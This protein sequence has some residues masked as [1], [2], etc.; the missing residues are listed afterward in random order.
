MTEEQQI[1]ARLSGHAGL[2]ALVGTRISPM[3]SIQAGSLPCVTFQRASGGRR[4]NHDGADDMAESS[5]Q[6]DAWAASYDGVKAVAEQLRAALDASESP[7]IGWYVFIDNETDDYEEDTGIY[8]VM[9]LAT[10]WLR[11]TSV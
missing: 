8:R 7:L 3:R 6:F 10:C 5:W 1:Y 9:I 2:A 11:R 4:Y